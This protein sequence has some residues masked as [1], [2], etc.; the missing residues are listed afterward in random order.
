MS[1]FRLQEIRCGKIYEADII[2][3]FRFLRENWGLELF[4]FVSNSEIRREIGDYG[5]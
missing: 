4:A 2:K 5:R 3:I 1:D